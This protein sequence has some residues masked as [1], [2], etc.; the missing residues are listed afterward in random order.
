MG[1]GIKVVRIGQPTAGVAL[2]SNLPLT[3]GFPLIP[4][5]PRT[6]V[7]GE[8]FGVAPLAISPAVYVIDVVADPEGVAIRISGGFDEIETQLFVDLNRRTEERVR[9]GDRIPGVGYFE[10]DNRLLLPG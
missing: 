7:K 9:L 4:A 10:V 8:W 2:V 5:F 1:V 6:D 3:T